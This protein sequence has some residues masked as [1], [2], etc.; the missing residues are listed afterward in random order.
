V[1]VLIL[2]LALRLLVVPAIDIAGRA[3]QTGGGEI[4]ESVGNHN[5]RNT[6]AISVER[7]SAATVRVCVLNLGAD[8]GGIN[9]RDD[10]AQ[11]G[12]AG[13]AGLRADVGHIGREGIEVLLGSNDLNGRLNS[14]FS[15]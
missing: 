13:E 4:G 15:G 3:I 10:T 8:D 12:V 6:H 9:E 5:I 11:N 2:V 14:I 7:L 1:L